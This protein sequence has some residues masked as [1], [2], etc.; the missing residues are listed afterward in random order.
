MRIFSHGLLILSLTL[1]NSVACAANLQQLSGHVVRVVDGDTL[2]IEAGDERH[3]VRLGGIDA[4]E[5]SQPWGD[6]STREL[7]RQ[8][9]G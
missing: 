1:L 5:R 8:A 7:R 3:K 4:P 9:V 2:V 6:A